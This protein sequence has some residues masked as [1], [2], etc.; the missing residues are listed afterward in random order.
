MNKRKLL[1][2]I[3]ATAEV[4]GRLLSYAAGALVFGLR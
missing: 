3:L 2:A 1:S 4:L